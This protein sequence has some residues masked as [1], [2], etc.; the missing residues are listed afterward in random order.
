MG[1]AHV[2]ALVDVAMQVDEM[3]GQFS[4]PATMWSQTGQLFVELAKQCHASE[5]AWPL[6]VSEAMVFIDWCE[7][8]QIAQH[9]AGRAIGLEAALVLKKVL[10]HIAERGCNGEC[11]HCARL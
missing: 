10:D 9:E 1:D 2:A 8:N 3:R 5:L 4:V 7:Q 6:L 11:L